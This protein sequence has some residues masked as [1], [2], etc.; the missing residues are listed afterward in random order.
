MHYKS[1]TMKL[2]CLAALA[3]AIPAIVA[4]DFALF[5]TT[6]EPDWVSI[7]GSN[8][9]EAHTN[10]F[11]G[12]VAALTLVDGAGKE[13][14]VVGGVP[15]TS[16]YPEQMAM[17]HVNSESVYVSVPSLFLTHTWTNDAHT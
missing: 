2:A 4:A 16:Y 9:L 12:K 15:M 8:I 17:F 1:T 5:Y 13:L 7:T 6:H 14:N 3:L 11:T 10:L